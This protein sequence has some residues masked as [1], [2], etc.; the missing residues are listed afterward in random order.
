V[1]GTVASWAEKLT[2]VLVAIAMFVVWH[3]W[4]SPYALLPIP[5]F[6]SLLVAELVL[7]RLRGRSYFSFHATLDNLCLGALQRTLV[8]I[9]PLFSFALY[10]YL[11]DYHR[12][13]TFRAG[14]LTTTLSCLLIY[15]FLFYWAH[16]KSHEINLMWAAHVVHHQSEEFNLSVGFRQGPFQYTFYYF[17][18]L[19]LALLGFDPGSFV[20]AT[21]VHQLAQFI[22]HARVSGD[23]G[24]MQWIFITPSTHGLHHAR[25]APYL[26]TNFGGILSTWD[27]LFGTYVEE[28]PEVEPSYGIVHQL[29]SW[30]PV[31]AVLMPW[32]DL[33]KLSRRAGSARELL[34]IWLG[35]PQDLPPRP[36]T[37]GLAQRKPPSSARGLDLY[38]F[39]QLGV[40]GIVAALLMA[41]GDSLPWTLKLLGFAF[42]AVTFFCGGSLFDRAT[43]AANLEF[44]RL[45]AL[46]VAALGASLALFVGWAPQLQ[47]AWLAFVATAFV[48]A[49]LVWFSRYRRTSAA[50]PSTWAR[51]PEIT[52]NT[53]P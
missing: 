11:Y 13:F 43:R 9:H 37:Q 21:V 25:N 6:A 50:S 12:L 23:M 49:S 22:V 36:D 17:F 26:D 47:P 34:R 46:L 14:S 5:F 8:V 4:G 40:A 32:A 44:V 35:R 10:F 1:A 33:V 3:F 41:W 15:D 27:R 45:G 28:D 29:E 39:V 19:P 2:V 42:V 7:S 30:N 18:F 16:R 24:R 52:R 20:V 51:L 53:A 31:S 48:V 38:A